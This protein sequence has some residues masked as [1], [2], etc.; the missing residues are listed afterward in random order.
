M[1]ISN[2]YTWHTFI[3]LYKNIIHREV[4]EK[5][6]P[7]IPIFLSNEGNSILIPNN[8]FGGMHLGHLSAQHLTI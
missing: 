7:T 4:L 6:Q 8:Y 1:K 3:R 5:S 2:W